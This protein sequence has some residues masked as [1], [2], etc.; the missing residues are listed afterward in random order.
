MLLQRFQNGESL[1]CT[2]DLDGHRATWKLVGFKYWIMQVRLCE[3]TEPAIRIAEDG[4]K[5][6]LSGCPAGLINFDPAAYPE[7]HRAIILLP[8]LSGLWN[9]VNADYFDAIREPLKSN[10]GGC[11]AGRMDGG[12]QV[13]AAIRR[14]GEATW[15]IWAKDPQPE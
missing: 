2:T 6:R 9:A 15:N 7:L 13:P 11:N 14:P 10:T 12:G 8:Q 3:S 5:T 4:T 1:H